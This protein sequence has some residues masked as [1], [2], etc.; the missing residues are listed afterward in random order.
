MV[1]LECASYFRP[2]RLAAAPDMDT[3]V[4]SNH[5]RIAEAAR[6]AGVSTSTLRLW[7]AHGLITPVRTQAGQRLFT[8]EQ[9]ARL[10][11]IARLRSDK[12]LNPAAIATRMGQ[13]KAGNPSPGKSGAAPVDGAGLP[14]GLRIR[15]LRQASH[16]TL[17]AI[18]QAT[19]IPVSTLSTF[20]RTSVGVSFKSLHE[21]AQHFNTTVA[22]LNGQADHHDNE[23]LVRAGEWATWPPT[24]PGVTVQALSRGPS[25]MECHRF[26]LAPGASSEGTYSHAGEEFLHILA[27]SI[28]IS[29]D[30]SRFFLLAAGDSFYFESV[31]PHAWRNTADVPAVVIWINT[32]ATF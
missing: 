2:R 10:K 27:G 25:L 16:Q 32:P 7:E 12:G 23:Y 15:R 24:S 13:D 21:L 17:E 8:V 11:E 28:E 1:Y 14:V 3:N 29:L 18:S 26:E 6:I 19:G 22:A 4:K 31:R 20:E 9:L 30:S 5:F